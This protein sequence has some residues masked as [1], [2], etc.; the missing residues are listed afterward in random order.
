MNPNYKFFWND[1]LDGKSRYPRPFGDKFKPRYL[2]LDPF[3]EEVLKDKINLKNYYIKALKENP[4]LISN[5]EEFLNFIRF[6]HNLEDPPKDKELEFLCLKQSIIFYPT[7]PKGNE[8]YENY[9]FHY[10]KNMADRNAINTAQSYKDNK[11][12]NEFL[13]TGKVG[14]E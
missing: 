6:V 11:D 3:F 8:C 7:I 2:N 1:L 4:Y 5:I 10:L 14:Y 12:F 9:I 13:A